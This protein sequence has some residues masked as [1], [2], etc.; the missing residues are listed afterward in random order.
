MRNPRTFLFSRLLPFMVLVLISG[1]GPRL[2]IPQ[3]LAATDAVV[4]GDA[5]RAEEVSLEGKRLFSIEANLG[6][7][8]A[9]ERA[10]NIEAILERAR[11]DEDFVT[12]LIQAV[13]QGNHSDV[14]SGNTKIMTVT[15]GDA[16]LAGTTHQY[17]AGRYADRIRDTLSVD[18]SREHASESLF[19]SLQQSGIATGVLVVLLIVLQFVTGRMRKTLRAWRGKYIRSIRLQEVELLKEETLYAVLMGIVKISKLVAVWFLIFTY[20]VTILA[21]FPQTEHLSMRL[22]DSVFHTASNVIVPSVIGYAPNLCFLLIILFGTRYFLKFISFITV[23]M[24]N[25]TLKL[26]GFEQEWVN[27]TS[28]IVKF[29]VIVFATM[30]A[31][32]YLPGSDSPAFQQVAIFLGVLV[33]LG[34]SGAVSN[35]I[36][37]IFLTYTGAFR[38]NDR[39]RIADTVGDVIYISLL[40]TRIKT[41]KQE[42]I[43]VPNGLVLGSHIVNY[44]SSCTDPG[45]ILHTEVTLGYD[46]PWRKAEALLKEAASLTELISETPE[47]FVLQTSLND[48]HVAYQLNAYTTEPGKMALIYSDL[49]RNIQD[50][51]REAKVEILSPEYRAM[52]DGN[53]STIPEE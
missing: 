47:P 11:N 44:S 37:G 24:A 28:N 46:V 48:H 34:S 12:G 39:V 49:H 26:P 14:V 42:V 50:V 4:S 25:G 3:A 13:D 17:L 43:T 45:L 5:P 16:N 15:E 36:A 51:F 6:P 53:A 7:I 10:A 22:R 9:K 30:L 2:M 31:F 33:S 52:R 27:P 32:P 20:A 40:A 35:I 8:T 23:Q 29:G 19:T 21:F 18:R 38:M 41:I 1:F